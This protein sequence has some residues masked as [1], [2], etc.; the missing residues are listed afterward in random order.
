MCQGMGIVLDAGGLIFAFAGNN[1]IELC[2]D[3][4]RQYL[5][6]IWRGEQQ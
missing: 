3:S 1:Y 2:K 4:E 6:Q 5:R